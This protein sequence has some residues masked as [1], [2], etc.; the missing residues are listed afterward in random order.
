MAS[1]RNLSSN[2]DLNFD[3][4]KKTI[5]QWVQAYVAAELKRANGK[6]V[7][8][9][10]SLL[11]SIYDSIMLDPH[12]SAVWE[13]RKSKVLGEDFGIFSANGDLND[14]LTDKLKKRWFTDND[15]GFIS[16]A[17]DA[18]AYGYSLIELIDLNDEG[19]IKQ[20]TVV[21]RANVVPELNWVL[22]KPSDKE[23]IDFT[24]GAYND[25]YILIRGGG[26]GM[27]LKAAPDAL[28][29]RYAKAAWLEHAEV[30][31]LDFLVGKTN[32]DDQER[33]DKL[34]NALKN[35]GRNRMAVIDSMDEFNTVSQSNTDPSGMYETLAKYCDGEI[36]KLIQGATGIS[37]IGSNYKEAGN[38][39]TVADERA[40]GDREFIENYVN[41][42]LLPRLPLISPYYSGFS[43]DVY[44]KFN[45]NNKAPLQ[46]RI[47]LYDMLLRNKVNISGEELNEEFGTRIEEVEENKEA[48]NDRPILGY[49]IETGVV[50]KNE[51]RAQLGL[52][53][54]DE[55]K[56]EANRELMGK[57]AIMKAAKEAGIPP[58][59][60]AKLA[61]LNVDVSNDLYEN[62]Q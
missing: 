56:D 20:I 52:P 61:G 28:Y 50:K 26:L 48:I 57:L 29:K 9:N 62:F 40:E 19:E 8:P 10:K 39:Q 36:S 24:K 23:G 60:A 49:H 34:L 44:F 6:V 27:L 31:S 55:S 22:K 38:H 11:I 14:E 54:E 30:H 15:T 21:N 47:K 45:T 4:G 43:G 37:D 53:E 42:D 35:A 5:Q 33:V 16:H 2:I 32:I 3:R 51:A 41:D 25:N 13:N 46:E 17:L 58:K 59:E 1:N 7:V 12:L 18:K